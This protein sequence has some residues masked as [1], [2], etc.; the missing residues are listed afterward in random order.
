MIFREKI[1][2]LKEKIRQMNIE[3]GALAIRKV[4]CHHHSSLSKRL[5][6]SLFLVT[7][8]A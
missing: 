8:Y 2:N 6:Y 5:N 3:G 1:V 7:R 4:N